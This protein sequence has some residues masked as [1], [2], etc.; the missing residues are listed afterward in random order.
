MVYFLSFPAVVQWIKTPTSLA[1]VA[2]EP[3]VWSPALL[4]VTAAAQIQFL[5]WEL[6]HAVGAAI[7]IKRDQETEDMIPRDHRQNTLRHKSQQCFLRSVSQ[8]NRNKSKN[9]QMGLKTYELL[10]RKGNHKQNEPTTYRAGEDIC[11]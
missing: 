3:W 8:G 1:W 9:K 5:T 6:P 10:D 11:K 2:V 7:K 4:Q